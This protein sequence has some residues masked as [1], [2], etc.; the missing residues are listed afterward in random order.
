MIRRVALLTLAL[1]G[2]G[3]WA[4]TDGRV[5]AYTDTAAHPHA[6]Q[7]IDLMLKQAV[8]APDGWGGWRVFLLPE[9]V[10]F[11]ESEQLLEPYAMLND[12]IES[13]ELVAVGVTLL[14]SGA[15]A[16]VSLLREGERVGYLGKS[17]L[18]GAR[19]EEG[20][21]RG[22]LFLASSRGTQGMVDVS[23]DAAVFLPASG[24]PL[25]PDGGDPWRAFLDLRSALA[26]DDR[27]RFGELFSRSVRKRMQAEGMFDQSLD[28]IR[29]EFPMDAAFAEGWQTD[30]DAR[31]VLAGGGQDRHVFHLVKEDGQWRMRGH[32]RR[33]ADG[34]LF[35]PAPAAFSDVPDV[36][37]GRLAPGSALGAELVVSGARMHPRYAIA[38]PMPGTPG[39]FRILVTATPLAVEHLKLL[40]SGRSLAPLFKGGEVQALLLAT[41]AEADRPVPI[42]IAEGWVLSQD[43]GG[44]PKFEQT[45]IGIGESSVVMLDGVLYGQIERRGLELRFAAPVQPGA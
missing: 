7:R 5:L 12:R 37:G 30:I 42:E 11:D 1:A 21:L 44:H 34:P 31:L 18:N 17:R 36:E 4:S 45:S 32:S 33:P 3:A 24:R 16:N 15:Q 6:P 13:L 22:H 14:E 41:E 26:A 2:S 8:A 35:T 20:R 27:T 29:A 39:Q 23:I 10:S 43:S 9:A 28:A 40:D 19:I 25:P 38:T